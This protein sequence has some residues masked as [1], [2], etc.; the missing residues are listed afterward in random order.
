MAKVYTSVDEFLK[1]LESPEIAL[2]HQ[3]RKEITN[4]SPRLVEDLKWNA[5]S[6]SLNGND[7]IT[8]NFRNFENVALVFHTGPKGKDTHTGTPLFNG[9]KE[10]LEWVADKRFVLR[11]E[12]AGW[13]D[14]NKATLSAL[15]KKWIGLAEHGFER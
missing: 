5:P 2:I 6:Y 11:I 4:A 1:D 8:F 15:V 3:I 7:I 9:Y 13:L 12:N 14:E 10:I